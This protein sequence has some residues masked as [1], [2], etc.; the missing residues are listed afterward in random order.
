MDY[1]ELKRPYFDSNGNP[2]IVL[3]YQ[4]GTYAACFLKKAVDNKS[5]HP[6]FETLKDVQKFLK[7]N[8]YL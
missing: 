6:D 8:G 2:A 7:E 3:K 5:I 4:N 1:K